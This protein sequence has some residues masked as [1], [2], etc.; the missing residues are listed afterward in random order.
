MAGLT[1]SV[2]LLIDFFL[3]FHSKTFLMK[4]VSY[5]FIFQRK[6]LVPWRTGNYTDKDHLGIALFVLRRWTLRCGKKKERA[7]ISKQAT[8]LPSVP[9]RVTIKPQQQFSLHIHRR[10]ASTEQCWGLGMAFE[11]AEAQRGQ[12]QGGAKEVT[13]DCPCLPVPSLLQHTRLQMSSQFW[14]CLLQ[15]GPKGW[16]D[17]RISQVSFKIIAVWWCP[18][19][20]QEK[21]EEVKCS[22]FSAAPSA[23]DLCTWSLHLCLI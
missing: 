21:T 11:K 1:E 18:F 4:E 6:L 13:V 15:Q 9:R 2:M 3:F 16:R 19:Y 10:T 17:R 22:K 12:R 20:S 5:W 7:K 23:L 8:E 14:C